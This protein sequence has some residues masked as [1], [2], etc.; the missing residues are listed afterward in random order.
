MAEV[1]TSRGIKTPRAAVE[2]VQIKELSDPFLIRDMEKAAELINSAVEEGL[3]ICIY[4][5]YDC[6]GV[7][8]TAMLYT[9]LQL[10]GAQVSYYIP[11][12]DEGYGMSCAAVKKLHDDGVEMI[13]TVDNG[14][15]AIEEA[16]LIKSLGMRLIITDHHQVP[17]IMPEAEAIVDPHRHDCPS[18]FKALCGAGVVLKLIAALDGGEYDAAFEQ[19]GDLAAIGTIADIVDVS[20]ENRFIISR[21]IALLENTERAGLRSLIEQCGLS[22]KKL[23]SASIGFMLTPKINA[24][25][26]F[27]SPL[28]A[29]KL[30]LCEDEAEATELSAQLLQLNN[31]R[32]ECE[33]QIMAEIEKNISADSSILDRTVLCFSGKGWYHGVIGIIS[34]RLMERFGKP[35]FVISEDENGEARGSAR[36]FEGFSVFE[37]LNSCSE[38]LLNFGGHLGAG[39]FS[40]K[41]SDIDEFRRRI[42]GYAAKLSEPPVMTVSADKLLH[43]EDFDVDNIKG[44]TLLEPFGSGNSEPVF[45]ILGAR[46]DAVIPVSLGKHTKLKLLYEGLTLHAMLFGCGLSDVTVSQ[47]D[48]VDMLV[49]LEENIWNDKRSISIKI[50]DYRC[51]GL[52]Q[53]RY[54]AAKNTYEGYKCGKTFPQSYYLRMTPKREE[55]VTIYKSI[56]KSSC[57]LDLIYA[58]LAG[59]LPDMNYCK[60]RFGIDAFEELG[61]IEVNHYASTAVLR[62]VRKKVNLDDSKL[63]SALK[64]SCTAS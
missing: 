1:L 16:K 43:K 49:T 31:E 36:S 52:D 57:S 42:L 22:G 21:G 5:D 18:V 38:L 12:R 46:V 45:A 4:G 28:T 3:H 61:L 24:A 40:L 2:F 62:E 6:D 10:L 15:S 19:F 56:G 30:L 17:D 32:R 54:F 60:F 63:L 64:V 53:K 9:Y 37:A 23:N 7:T 59:S 58:R 20:G 14:I 41:C 33:M 27:G 55:L 13:I 26:R 8:A 44:L 11:E 51:S 25:G 50:K 39:G 48:T 35:C 29:L 34:A 47:G